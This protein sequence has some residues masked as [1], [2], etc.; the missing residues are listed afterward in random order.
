VLRG[1]LE[2]FVEAADPAAPRLSSIVNGARAAP[3][4]LGSDNPDN[5]YQQAVISGR[6]RYRVRGTRGTVHYLG[7]G[8]Q[9]GQYGRP[10]GLR[11][12]S[13]VDADALQRRADG[14]FEIIISAERPAAAECGRDSNWLPSARDPEQGLLLVRQTFLDR[15]HE[16]LAELTIEP[17][18]APAVPAPW[19]CAQLEEGLEAATT[20]LAGASLMFVKWARGFQQHVNELPLFDQALSDSVGGDPNIRYFHSYWRLRRDEALVIEA[21]PPPCDTWNFQLNNY[22]AFPS[23]SLNFLFFLYTYG[24]AA[25]SLTFARTQGWRVWITATTRSPT[26][27]TR[28][29]T[30]PTARCGSLCAAKTPIPARTLWATGSTR[31]PTSK[32]PCPGAGSSRRRCMTGCTC[33]APARACSRSLHWVPSTA[34]R[35]VRSRSH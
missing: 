26:T 18:D 5:F 29:G 19:S 2:N 31:A 30:F 13:F 12:V 22:C 1:A 11:T 3:V 20:M 35:P 32:A 25:P 6:R 17:L 21:T 28:R 8:V 24:G 10:G 27:S 4:K 9:A 34:P 7:L 23:P 16:V 14:S 33:P 15:A